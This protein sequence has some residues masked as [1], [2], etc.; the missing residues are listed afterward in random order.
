MQISK[1]KSYN[2]FLSSPFSVYAL[3]WALYRL[4]GLL[5]VAGNFFSQLILVGLLFVSLR[6]ACLIYTSKSYK[7]L[8]FRGLGLMILLFTVYG[9]ILIFTDGAVTQGLMLRP[10]T[11]NYL[12]DYYVSLLPIITCYYYTQKGYLNEILLKRWVAIFL[13]LGMLEYFFSQRVIAAEMRSMGLDETNVNNTGY[14][15]VSMIPCLLIFKKY[16]IQYTCMAL[17][18]LF[19]FFSMKRG[20][21]ICGLIMVLF[22]IVNNMRS[23]SKEKK[24]LFF[25]SLSLLFFVVVNIL[26]AS[27][28]QND[29]YQHR[30]EKTLDGDVSGRDAFF[31]SMFTY[32]KDSETPLEQ[33]VGLGANGTLKI[34][35]NYAHNDW[36]EILINQGLLG[37]FFYLL[38]WL[39]FFK[40]VK[41][42][43]ISKLSREIIT[44]VLL[45][46]F[47]KTF[48]SMSIS[49]Y[50]IYLSSIFGFALAD[51]F[52]V[53]VKY[54][55]LVNSH[56]NH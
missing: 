18:L 51:G 13:L 48:F 43:R 41:R 4:Q 1:S 23:F 12:K 15:M 32:Y 30:Y 25:V 42:S 3:C 19:V 44:M 50:N 27:L 35:S 7:P 16:W 49:N 26:E 14:I 37:I 46:T 5:F 34:S 22:H 54:P 29:F 47:M 20:A 39:S 56:I 53:G 45:F 28:F 31:S 24:I 6:H 8:F 10:P 9:I 11:Y 21:I 36:L 55:K 40:T 17:C 52:L 38:Y 33:F 2:S